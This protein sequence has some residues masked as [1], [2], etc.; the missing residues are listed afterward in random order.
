M[1]SQ[2]IRVPLLFMTV[3]WFYLIVGIILLVM[4]EA[5][6]GSYGRDPVFM[7]WFFG[8]VMQMIM[9]VSTLFLPSRLHNQRR[10]DH[11]M[12]A[13]LILTNAGTV[14]TGY[15]YI[16]SPKS[17]FPAAAVGLSMIMAAV[18]LHILGITG[19][20]FSRIQPGSERRWE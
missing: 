19:A 6:I 17:L 11:R 4:E 20:V 5:G 10:T 15:I 12:L 8:F 3:A 7:I 2:R 18:I 13:E 14:L 1:I 9:G 16:S